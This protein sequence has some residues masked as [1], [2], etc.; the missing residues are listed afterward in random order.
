M[1]KASAL[2]ANQDKPTTTAGD[3]EHRI[4]ELRDYRTMVGIVW[5]NSIL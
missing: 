3:A 4:I 2:C 5:M 1:T